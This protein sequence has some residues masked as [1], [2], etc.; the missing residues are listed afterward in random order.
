[1]RSLSRLKALQA[2]EATARHGSF[3]GAGR[4]LNV[5]PAAVGQMVRSLEEWLG[6]PLFRRKGAGADR[7]I[8]LE[9][10]TEALAR[11]NSGLDAMD[12]AMRQLR[13][14]RAS[15][16]VTVSASQAI[17]AK[18]LLPH[19]GDLASHHPDIVVRLDVT[20]RVVDLINGEADIGIRCGSG[21]WQG[22]SATYLR[23]EE[24]IVVCAPSLL[25]V[26]GVVDI[27]WLGSQTLLHDT[28]P[29]ALGVFPDWRVWG[30]M[31]GASSLNPDQGVKINASTAIIQA[32]VSGQGVA[33][34]RRALV[35]QDIEELRLVHLF[36]NSCLP[37]DW[38]YYAVVSPRALMRPPVRAFHDWLVST[39]R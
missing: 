30:D 24:I 17:V 16:I 12:E 25:P 18:W 13:T 28:T 7:L 20:D 6:A 14:R 21:A 4:E 23:G 3:V 11:L 15:S 33:L 39:W 38:A 9:D 32:A 37:I 29:A 8:A 27:Y 10:T 19:L 2:F 1:M 36:V 35:E 22:L 26:E 34:A 31:V 5:T